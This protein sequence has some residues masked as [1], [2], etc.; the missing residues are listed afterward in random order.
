[1]G[2]FIN[3]AR[4]YRDDDHKDIEGWMAPETWLTLANIRDAGSSPVS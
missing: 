4:V 2:R 3:R 1:L